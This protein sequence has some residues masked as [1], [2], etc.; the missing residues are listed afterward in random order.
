[1][2]KVEGVL[3]RI[4]NFSTGIYEVV[5]CQNEDELMHYLASLYGKRMITSV[6]RLE[7]RGNAVRTPKVAVSSN[8]LYKQLIKNRN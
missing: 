2:R 7:I 4:G 8:P 5:E 3:Y 6:V 1:M